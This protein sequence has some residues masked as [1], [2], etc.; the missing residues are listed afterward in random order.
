M[1]YNTHGISN[2]SATRTDFGQTQLH[3]KKESG[4]WLV[5]YLPLLSPQVKKTCSSLFQDLS[6]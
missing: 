4:G 6:R 3:W 5:Q 2:V 1:V